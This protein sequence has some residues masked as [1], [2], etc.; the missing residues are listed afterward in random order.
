MLPPW[1]I[2]KL[3][4]ERRER[5]A[6]ERAAPR[7]EIQ[8]PPDEYTGQERPAPQSSSVITIQVW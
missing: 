8:P 3:E 2:E 5:E 4:R 6:R 1:T 7:V